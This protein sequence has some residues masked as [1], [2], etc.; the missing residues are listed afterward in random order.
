MWE[1][2]HAC[3][4]VHTMIIEC[5]RKTRANVHVG[6]YACQG[7]LADV[8]HHVPTDFADCLVMHV[9]IREINTYQQLQD[10]MIEHLWRLKR[11]S[12]TVSAG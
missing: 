6:P 2:I 9:E 1:M 7:H 12:S 4:I 10:N 5:D 8:E 11:E 3:V